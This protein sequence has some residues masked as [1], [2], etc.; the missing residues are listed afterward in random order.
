MS[1]R[2]LTANHTPNRRWVDPDLR[3]GFYVSVNRWPAV[4]A[5]RLFVILR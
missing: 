3:I 2:D 1:F 4:L 5:A